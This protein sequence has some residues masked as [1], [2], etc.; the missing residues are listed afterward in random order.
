[1]TDEQIAEVYAWVVL[2][3]AFSGTIFDYD[4]KVAEAA[5]RLIGGD[6]SE[7]VLAVLWDESERILREWDTDE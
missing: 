5:D 2:S 6:R 4:P 7:E 1:M 3:K